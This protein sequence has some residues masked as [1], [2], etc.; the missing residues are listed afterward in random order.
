[1]INGKHTMPQNLF[2][3]HFYLFAMYMIRMHTCMYVICVMHSGTHSAHRHTHAC[4][5][6]TP[7]MHAAHSRLTATTTKPDHNNQS[8][9]RCPPPP[10]RWLQSLCLSQLMWT[11]HLSTAAHISAITIITP[12]ITPC[13]CCLVREIRLWWHVNSQSS[14][15]CSCDLASFCPGIMLL[16]S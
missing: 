1:M 8:H 13:S 12:S 14:R 6:Q 16:L 11:S 5:V 3:M 9:I 4:T 10:Q 7:P 2:A 15:S